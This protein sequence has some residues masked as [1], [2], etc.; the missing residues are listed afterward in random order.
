MV[1]IGALLHLPGEGTQI[2]RKPFV[3]A[4]WVQNSGYILQQAGLGKSLKI[5]NQFSRGKIKL[6]R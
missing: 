6:I 1:A 2:V 4:M 3:A 5:L